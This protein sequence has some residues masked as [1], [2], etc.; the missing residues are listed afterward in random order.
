MQ[1]L[2]IGGR[3]QALAQL[4]VAEQLGDLG[5]DFQVLCVAASGTSKKISRP[6]G[7][8][9]GASKPMGLAR[10][11]HCRHGSRRRPLMQPWECNSMPQTGR[12]KAFAC[13]QAIGDQ[14][15][16]PRPMKLS[17]V[18]PFPRKARFLLVTSTL[19]NARRRE[20]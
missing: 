8:S 7:C 2:R 4:A 14:G 9:S 12:A 1:L 17:K 16:R 6:T 10:L 20:G 13:E 19:T 11:E 18:N 15:T 3:L 5:R